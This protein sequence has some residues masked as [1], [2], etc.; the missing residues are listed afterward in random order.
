ME[1]ISNATHF[2]C[3]PDPPQVKGDAHVRIKFLF[4]ALPNSGA[5]RPIFDVP[6]LQPSPIS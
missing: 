1:L 4:L 3:N 6:G 2:L 5:A